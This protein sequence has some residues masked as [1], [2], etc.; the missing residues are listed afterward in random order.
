[1]STN[2]FNIIEKVTALKENINKSNHSD[3]SSQSSKQSESLAAIKK[4]FET[5]S[6]QESKSAL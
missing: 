3:D 2:S 4:K 5:N 1:M 6:S